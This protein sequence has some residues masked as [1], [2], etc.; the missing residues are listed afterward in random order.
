MNPP[1]VY[2]CSPSWT[3]LPPASPY[4]PSGSSQCTSL[5][6]ASNLDWQFLPSIF[7]PPWISSSMAFHVMYSA[8]KLN[9]QGNNI[10][11]WSTT[12]PVLNK[13]IVPCLVLTVASWPIY[14]ILRRQV[15]WSGIPF[16]LRKSNR[17]AQNTVI[18]LK[19]FCTI[20]KKKITTSLLRS[21]CV[22]VCVCVCV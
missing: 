10:Q 16:S 15:R 8:Y 20:Y 11:P 1:R 14:R 19:S 18:K 22:C 21:V 6:H 5:Y 7:I 2:T 12:F 9:K 13:F 4:H 3:S 17:W